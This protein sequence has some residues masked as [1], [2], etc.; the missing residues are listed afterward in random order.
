[1]P[2]YSGLKIRLHLHELIE[3]RFLGGNYNLRNLWLKQYLFYYD[4]FMTESVI[5]SYSVHCSFVIVTPSDVC[6]TVEGSVVTEVG[7]RFVTS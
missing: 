7:F 5:S 3:T 6:V 2:L 1:M 4:V